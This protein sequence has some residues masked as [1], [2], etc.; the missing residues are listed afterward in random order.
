MKALDQL[1]KTVLLGTSRASADSIEW[2]QSV[3]EQLQKLIKEDTESF[4]LQGAA[5]MFS[6]QE[7]GQI[8]PRSSIAV[9]T[10]PEEQQK[11]C[12][13]IAS[14][15]LQRILQDKSV[16]LI[17][18]W[19]EACGASHQ[20]VHPQHLPHLLNLGKNQVSLRQSLQ[21]VMGERG[22]WL[23]QMNP[24]WAYVLSTDEQIWEE[25]KAEERKYLLQN[26]RK[27]DAQ[28]ALSLL[29]SSWKSESADLRAEFLT[30]LEV[31]LSA[32]DLPFLEEAL[33][34]KSKK[35]KSTALNLL[36]LQKDSFIVQKIFHAASAMLEVKK[37]KSLFGLKGPVIAFVSASMDHQLAEYGVNLESLDK[38]FS[39]E[40]YYT[41]EL[42]EVID[43]A[44]W[45]SHFQMEASA[46]VHAFQKEE[47]LA[48]FIPAL[49]EASVLHRNSHWA[50]IFA[51]YLQKNKIV[52]PKDKQYLVQ[53]VIKALSKEEKMRYFPA[54]WAALSLLDYLRMCEFSWTADF[55]RKALQQLYRQYME[56]G[57]NPSERDKMAALHMYLHPEILKEKNSFLPPDEER[58]AS[59]REAVELLFGALEL[60]TS[61]HKAFN[62]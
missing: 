13:K 4:L 37:N 53:E 11:Y 51:E 44:H 27:K 3:G 43:P 18:Q 59:W 14:Q 28:A 15:L 17:Q 45:E 48:K 12:S 30:L 8:F 54:P 5:L 7:A 58:K 50:N 32:D 60:R 61:I 10:A 38:N 20:I 23:S 24:D 42:I 26:L 52:L 55:S 31:N 34:D 40:A 39:N 47:K 16:N 33:L 41:Y 57:I 22:K 46:I 9:K 62:N 56:I 21:A 1:I 2:P 25:G 35:V 36:L 6:Y 19:L 29:Q 49:I